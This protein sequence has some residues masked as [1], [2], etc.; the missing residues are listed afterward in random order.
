[1]L[2][3]LLLL[4]PN[5]ALAICSVDFS[6]IA[7]E[8][9]AMGVKTGGPG[10]EEEDEDGAVVFRD[11]GAIVVVCVVCIVVGTVADISEDGCDDA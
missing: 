7:V 5:I 3:P 11:G 9:T 2:K 4:P 10:A 8:F 6:N 1:M